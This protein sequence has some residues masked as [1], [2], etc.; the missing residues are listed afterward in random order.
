MPVT[1]ADILERIRQSAAANGGVPPGSRRFATL[2]GVRESAWR[3]K[4]WARWSDAV[5]E[6]GFK[7]NQLIKAYATG[8]L[9]EGYA[10]LAVRIGRLPAQ[11]DVQMAAHEG[12]GLPT[13]GALVRPFGG[14][15]NLV[16]KLREHCI[17]RPELADVFQM[18]NAHRAT[19]AGDP[20]EAAGGEASFGCVYLLRHGRRDEYKIGRV[21]D[22]GRS[23]RAIRRAGSLRLQLPE[24]VHPVH[25]I[26]TDD[27]AGLEAY[28]HGRFAARR[29]DGEW[30][31]LTAADVAAFR[32]RKFM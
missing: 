11:G 6:A 5:A 8:D 10:R 15:A 20:G 2:T 31:E 13:W 22:V 18:C 32:R 12:I 24:K 17:G 26:T 16:A 1:K 9:L 3:G 14:K 27:P 25:V 30:F 7:P 28:G 21:F 23:F 4:L 29:T 19:D